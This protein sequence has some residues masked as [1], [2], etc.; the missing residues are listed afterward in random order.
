DDGDYWTWTLEEVRAVLNP[1]ES[2]VVAR[3]FDVLE[4]GEMHHNPKKNVLW[5]K[6]DPTGD[7]E[8][9]ILRRAMQRL[10][11]ARDGRTSPFVDRTAYVN[12]NA[13]MAGAMLQAGAGL[14]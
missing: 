1:E 3:V 12:W 14:D 8:W 10:K 7:D 5:W 6:Q 2:A 11:T 13:M 4:T 9:P